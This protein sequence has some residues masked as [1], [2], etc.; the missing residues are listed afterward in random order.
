MSGGKRVS[1]IAIERHTYGK[2]VKEKEAR[3]L[4]SFK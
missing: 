1:N 3:P 4:P 2:T